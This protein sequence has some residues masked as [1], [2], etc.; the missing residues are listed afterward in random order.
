MGAPRFLVA[1]AV[2][3]ITVSPAFAAGADGAL[4]LNQIQRA[5]TAESYKQAPSEGT[6]RVIGLGGKKNARKLDFEQPSLT[7]QLDNGAASLSFD[8]AYDPQGGLFKS[9]A[10]AS[11]ADELLDAD[12]EAAMSHPWLQ[13]HPCAGCGL[14]VQLSHL[15]SLPW[16][17]GGVVARP[18]RPS[19]D[20]DQP[21]GQ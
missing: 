20:R 17:S 19:A 15:E 10:G 2:T 13:G 18:S 21:F 6:L 5:G 7:A 12:Y 1:L 16:R 3:S 9:P 11:M 4:T 14:Q 8:I